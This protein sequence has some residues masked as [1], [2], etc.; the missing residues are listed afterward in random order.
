[1]HPFHGCVS[2]GAGAKGKCAIAAV[3]FH[4]LLGG[5]GTDRVS[6]H[7]EIRLVEE[8]AAVSS[9]LHHPPR[10]KLDRPA[11]QT[12]RFHCTSIT[13]PKLKLSN[14]FKLVIPRWQTVG[15]S[16]H[17]LM[18]ANVGQLPPLRWLPRRKRSNPLYF[19]L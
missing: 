19:L 16:D 4:L 17:L 7:S 10:F 13:H 8:D 5:E 9:D 3:R 18:P 6:T 12:S 2:R 14:Y 11:P 1:M 15:D